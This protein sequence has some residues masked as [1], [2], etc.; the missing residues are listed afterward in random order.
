MKL[1][2]I[3]SR[4]V[5]PNGFDEYVDGRITEIVSG[6]AAGV[7]SCAS[8]YAKKHGIKL[9]EFLPDYNGFGRAAPIVRNKLIVE[10]ADEVL[11]F[12]DG[13]SRGT[14]SAIRYSEKLGK[15]CKIII[16]KKES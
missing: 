2:I 15:P 7:D 5:F 11:A 14:L 9:V 13:S 4:G 16:C 1:A 8:A 12:W 6:G 3:G 10:Y